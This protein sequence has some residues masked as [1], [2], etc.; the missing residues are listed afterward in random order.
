MSDFFTNLGVVPAIII[1]VMIV[2]VIVLLFNLIGTNMRLGR[3]ERKYKMFMKGK[4]GQSLERE[5]VRKFA[6]I[7]RLSESDVIHT[8]DIHMLKKALT[9]FSANTVLKNM[10]HSM[11]WEEN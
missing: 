4:D 8:S 9:V 3:L 11:M 2:L 10:M 5:F 6:A 7:D 1:L